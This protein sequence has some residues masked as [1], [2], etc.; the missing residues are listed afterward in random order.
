L[1]EVTVAGIDINLG[2]GGAVNP[3]VLVTSFSM[4]VA[5]LCVIHNRLRNPTFSRG[6]TSVRSWPALPQD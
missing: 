2:L 4:T 5:L 1:K 6:L 3:G